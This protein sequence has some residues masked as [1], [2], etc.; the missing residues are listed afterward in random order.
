MRQQPEQ[1]HTNKPP[2]S[3][4]PT[5]PRVCPP[6]LLPRRSAPPRPT[7]RPP[8]PRRAS[9]SSRATSRI[10]TAGRSNADPS[11]HDRSRWI[12]RKAGQC[13]SQDLR[14]LSRRFSRATTIAVA[15]CRFSLQSQA[16]R[17]IGGRND[18]GD[19]EQ[20][21]EV[22]RSPRPATAPHRRA[23]RNCPPR[24]RGRVAPPAPRHGH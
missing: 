16:R 13:S 2:L 7:A 5:L 18:P 17:V 6:G 14:G 9:C 20:P 24:S 8:D 22:V 11:G 21:Q 23:P 1:P 12:R 4:A 3:D 19:D 10:P 15:N